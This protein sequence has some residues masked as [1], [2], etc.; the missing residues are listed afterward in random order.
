[1]SSKFFSSL[2]ILTLAVTVSCSKKTKPDGENEGAGAGGIVQ[3]AM[4][5]P[6]SGSDAGTIEGLYTINFAYDSSVLTAKAR[7]ILKGNAKWIN[8]NGSVVVQIEGHCDDRGSVEYNLALGERRAQ[9]VKDYLV[10]IG[11]DSK[12]LTVISFGK[13]KPLEVGDSE[14][15]YAKNRRANFVPLAN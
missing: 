10:S 4:D 12:R 11:V 9:S 6:A 2:L 14:T 13:E 8:A 7:E 3:E 1:M 15:V 5:F